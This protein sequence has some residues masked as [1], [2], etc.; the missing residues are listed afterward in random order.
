MGFGDFEALPIRNIGLKPLHDIN[1][2]SVEITRTSGDNNA[3]GNVKTHTCV[4][5]SF[6]ENGFD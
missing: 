1:G 6:V 2:G 4:E 3:L 5:G